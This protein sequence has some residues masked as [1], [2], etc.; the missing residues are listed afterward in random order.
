MADMAVGLFAPLTVEVL[1]TFVLER[2]GIS[3]SM[4]L[5]MASARV[6]PSNC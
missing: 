2:N 1:C 5:A 4:Y 3:N 6:I